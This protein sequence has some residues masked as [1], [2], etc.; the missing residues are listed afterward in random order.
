MASLIPDTETKGCVLRR[1]EFYPIDGGRRQRLRLGKITGRDGE[2]FKRRLEDVI[3]DLRLGHPHSGNL[4]EWLNGL[5]SEMQQRLH[6][7]G[8]MQSARQSAQNLGD[9]LDQLQAKTKVKKGTLTAYGHTVRNLKEHFGRSRIMQTIEP[10]HAEEFKQFLQEPERAHGK[11]PLAKA[12]VN[13]RVTL[14][15]QFFAAAKKQ[16]LIAENP[17]EDGAGGHQRNPDRLVFVEA[18]L[19]DKLVT[20]CDSQD[21]KL[22]LLLGRY[23]AVIFLKAG[24]TKN[25]RVGEIKIPDDLAA[26]LKT[27]IVGKD[28]DDILFP[29]PKTSGS[30]VDMLRRDLEGAGIVWE[31][32]SGEV[33][34]FHS[35]RATAVCWWLD[36]DPRVL[37]PKRVQILARMSTIARLDR[38]SRNL[39]MGDYSWLNQG[40]KLVEEETNKKAG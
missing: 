39:R 27:Y 23:P 31:L 37:T 24:D 38:Y 2:E 28:P 13:R 8:L 20:S 22:L 40:P 30:I 9:F 15:R 25:K 21:W 11:R 12:T 5:Q 14:A 6:K 16:K 33:I 10:R 34:D 29:F 17:F 35:L 36:Q 19:V 7:L 4:C 18:A 3:R 32:P 26:A 1:I